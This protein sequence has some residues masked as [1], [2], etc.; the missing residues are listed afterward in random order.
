MITSNV[1]ERDTVIESCSTGKI[2]IYLN[3]PKEDIVSRDIFDKNV[4]EPWGFNTVYKYIRHDPSIGVFD[5]GANIGVIALQL[6]NV[7]RKVI[8]IE[9]TPQNTQ[10]LCA[11]IIENR[12]SE[13]TQVTVVHNT[14]SND[15]KDVPFAFPNKGEY[16]LGFVDQG[17][18][19]VVKE[20]SKM[21]G[22]FYRKTTVPLKAAILD[23]I[24]T[25]PEFKA[26]LKVFIKI[27]IQGFEHKVFEGSEKLFESGKVNGIFIEWYFHRNTTSGKFLLQKFQ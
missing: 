20:M 26:M 18:D 7:G 4:W 19:N 24:M 14:L 10:H 3:N 27:D 8:A 1:F 12:Y 6:A 13:L 21:F 2:N 9:P 25:L 5:I 16:A 22:K 17:K 23:D 15:H 11:S